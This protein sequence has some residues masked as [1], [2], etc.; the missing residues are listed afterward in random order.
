MVAGTEEHCRHKARARPEAPA[1][2]TTMVG[3]VPPCQAEKWSAGHAPGKRPFL[4]IKGICGKTSQRANRMTM[5]RGMVRMQPVKLAARRQRL[6]CVYHVICMTY[7]SLPCE[8]ASGNFLL[9]FI[10][11]SI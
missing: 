3:N 8:A 1:K 4:L 5:E 10:G 9:V 7:P 2:H 6:A 11:S